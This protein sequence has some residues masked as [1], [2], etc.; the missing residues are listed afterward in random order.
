MT[1]LVFAGFSMLYLKESFT[2]NHAVGFGLIAAGAFFVFKGP[3]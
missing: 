1:L 2:L 3:L